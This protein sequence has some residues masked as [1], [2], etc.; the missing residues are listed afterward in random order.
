M[1][2]KISRENNIKNQRVYNTQDHRDKRNQT[3]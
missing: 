3:V 2:E 1:K